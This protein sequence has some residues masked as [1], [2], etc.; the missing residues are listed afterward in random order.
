[1]N[2]YKVINQE[3]NAQQMMAKM[4]EAIVAQADKDGFDVEFY[5]DEYILTERKQE[6]K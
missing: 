3:Y 1:M 4:L 5:Q 2:A 6:S